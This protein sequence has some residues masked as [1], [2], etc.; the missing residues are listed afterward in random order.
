MS[1]VEMWEMYRH[2]IEEWRRRPDSSPLQPTTSPR[3][4][5]STGALGQGAAINSEPPKALG[6]L[7]LAAPL[8]PARG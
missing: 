7:A 8:T 6:W 2:F 5:T 4:V 3:G 1:S